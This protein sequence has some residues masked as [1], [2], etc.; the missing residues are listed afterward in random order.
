MILSTPYLFSL[1]L[2][3][4]TLSFAHSQSIFVSLL[5]LSQQTGKPLIRVKLVTLNSITQ[6]PQV[7][8]GARK[9]SATF[10][11]HTQLYKK[12]NHMIVFAKKEEANEENILMVFESLE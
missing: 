9:G 1:L 10:K 3:K 8:L 11:E 4:S 12:K 6:A 2:N 7:K 5:G